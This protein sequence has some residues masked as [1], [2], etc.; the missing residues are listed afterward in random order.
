MVARSAR[1]VQGG[2]RHPRTTHPSETGHS[3]RPL[4]DDERMSRPIQVVVLGAG[5]WGTTVASLAARNTPTLLWARDQTTVDD[6]NNNHRNTKYLGDIPLKESLRATNDLQEA[7]QSRRCSRRRRAVGRGAVDA[8]RD[9]RRP[10]R[11]G[12][13]HLAGQGARA[14]HSTAAHRGHRRRV[15]G[16]S[17]RTARRAEHRGRGRARLR[18]RGGGRHRGRPHRQRAVSAVLVGPV[19]RLPQPRRARLRT[20]R[21]PQERHRDRRGHG[22]GTRRRRQ[23]AGNGARP[24]GWRR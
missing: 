7:A 2:V 18:R 22:R 24:A 1:Q 16:A 17:G 12:S 14:G 21:N 23:H 15:A 20:R 9:R 13:G 10:A 11:L 3:A 8:R 4:R 6:V 5:S 19:P